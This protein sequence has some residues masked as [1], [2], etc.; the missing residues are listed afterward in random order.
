MNTRQTQD[1]QR[2]R[3]YDVVRKNRGEKSGGVRGKWA[4][5]SATRHQVPRKGGAVGAARSKFGERV[6]YFLLFETM[7]E[8]R[9]DFRTLVRGLPFALGG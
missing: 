3:G 6:F 5:R 9:F 7:L 8:A 4:K 2:E 1:A